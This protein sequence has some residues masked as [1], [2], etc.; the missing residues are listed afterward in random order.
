VRDGTKG[1]LEQLDVPLV[2]ERT[3]SSPPPP[4]ER[5]PRRPSPAA[6]WSRGRLWVASLA[7]LGVVLLVLA[8]CWGVAAGVGASQAP[9]QLVPTGLA[10]VLAAAVLGVGTLWGWRAT[11]GMVLLH[12]RFTGP[13]TLGQGHKVWLGWV[14]SLMLAGLPLLVGARGRTGAELLAGSEL[15]LG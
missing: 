6:Q 12:L 1:P 3:P 14:L 10:G 4:V 9:A 8:A 2:W 15:T 11:P 5:A 7:D 13:L